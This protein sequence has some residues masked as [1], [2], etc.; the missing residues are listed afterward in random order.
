MGNVNQVDQLEREIA[1]QV[2]RANEIAKLAAKKEATAATL[3]AQALL[4]KQAQAKIAQMKPSELNTA[5]EQFK[6]SVQPSYVSPVVNNI[7]NTS[8]MESP[9]LSDEQYQTTIIQKMIAHIKSKR[10]K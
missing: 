5:L 10:I 3:Q 6:P 2:K 4:R 8:V 1:R 9:K 7:P